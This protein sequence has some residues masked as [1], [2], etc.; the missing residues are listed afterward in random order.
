MSD[1]LTFPNLPN[2]FWKVSKKGIIKLDLQF[3][4]L[5]SLAEGK[6]LYFIFSSASLIEA[7]YAA[8]ILELYHS[9]FPDNQLFWNG[10][11]N[12][13]PLFRLQ[14]LA[15]YAILPTNFELSFPTP[16][17]KTEDSVFFN[18]LY[19]YPKYRTM[20]G[21]F[22]SSRNFFCG[23]Q[24]LEHS[25][26]PF[27]GKT[28]QTIIRS[29]FSSTSQKWKFKIDPN[30]KIILFLPFQNDLTKINNS[31]AFGSRQILELADLT[32]EY[33][34]VVLQEENDTVYPH[35]KVSYLP[36]SFDLFLSLLP[37]TKALISRMTD[38]YHLTSSFQ[39]P[40]HQFYYHAKAF[41]A[42]TS[43]KGIYGSFQGTKNIIN[44]TE[45]LQ[46]IKG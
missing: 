10:P 39:F 4:K 36:F 13:S 42:P 26:L 11:R 5:S 44:P 9:Y 22:T 35:P 19:H 12:F 24:I 2:I 31:Y 3:D 34:I 37:Q 20:E 32:S 7:S 41:Y 21:N 8:S 38:F 33:Q 46:C 1:L 45:I 15:S 43:T 25:L 17:H 18:L 16:I 23:T 29:N 14:S 27:K 28:P 30:K 40:I 6:K